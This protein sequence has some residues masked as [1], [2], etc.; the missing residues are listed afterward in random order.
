[1][2]FGGLEPFM[3]VGGTYLFNPVVI[4]VTFLVPLFAAATF[5]LVRRWT[6]GPFFGL[7]TFG[8]LVVMFAGFP[9]DSRLRAAL[10]DVYDGFP[11]L[12]F[13]RTTY[14]GMPLLALAL[15][16]LCG[17]GAAWAAAASRRGPWHYWWRYRRS[18]RYP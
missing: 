3:G 15:A 18:R 16:C 7:L 11:A 13:L 17:A 9:R 10:L 8:A 1:V 2:G 6:Y 4:V 5:P 14:K 12:Q